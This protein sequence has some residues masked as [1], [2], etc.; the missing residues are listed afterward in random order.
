M[1]YS[2]ENR[3]NLFPTIDEVNRLIFIY[4]FKYKIFLTLSIH[5]NKNHIPIIKTKYFLFFKTNHKN[6]KNIA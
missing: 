6:K 2:E 5:L 3:L 1:R 4:I